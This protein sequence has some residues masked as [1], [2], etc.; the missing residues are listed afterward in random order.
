MIDC[1]EHT[2]AKT[3][4]GYG[5]VYTS[6][7]KY[8]VAHRIEYEKQRGKIPNGKVLDHLCRNRGCINVEHL[9]VVTRGENVKRGEGI[10]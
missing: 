7:G 3:A 8:R 2:G 6:P 1:I 4:Y 10:Y 9:E 5:R